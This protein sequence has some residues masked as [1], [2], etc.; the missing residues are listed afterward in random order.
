MKCRYCNKEYGNSI[1]LSNHERGHNSE[2]NS[3]TG[4]KGLCW[5]SNYENI[6]RWEKG[7]TSNL[8]PPVGVT[9]DLTTTCNLRCNHCN[10]TRS[11]DKKLFLDYDEVIKII[12]YLSEWRDEY[13]N[14]TVLRSC[15]F[16]GGGE[17]T[18]HPK[19]TDIITYAHKK[20]FQVG[21]STNGTAL[22]NG[23]VRAA[24]INHAEFCGISMD[25]GTKET[26]CKIK[27]RK[28]YNYD[29]IIKGLGLLLKDY[30][31][32]R[33]RPRRVD[34]VYKFLITEYNQHEILLA[35][36]LAKSLGFSTFFARPAAVE[37]L[38]AFEGHKL[39]FNVEDIKSQM[40]TCKELETNKFKVYGS[41]NRVNPETYGRIHKFNKCHSTPLL[42]QICADGYW[43]QCIDKRYLEDAKICRW[44]YIRDVW[45][46][47][48]HR[49]IVKGIDLNK[50][51]R[52][53]AGNYNE[54]IEAIEGDTMYRFFP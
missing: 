5:S 54:Q 31:K 30:K 47:N 7:E 51:V 2:Y 11:L 45:G 46:S 24:I 23:E 10:A 6:L 16:A 32:S 35:A 36:K 50:C 53:A 21:I 41:F 3:F 14:N 8:L 28:D 40:T 42:M 37:G 13:C 27:N 15:C 12:D 17:P 20:G 19:F 26:W 43:Y 22:L 49:G 38:E 33:R 44:E 39:A 48:E 1:G 25:S 18:L 34:L 52:C 9:I 4:L 29:I